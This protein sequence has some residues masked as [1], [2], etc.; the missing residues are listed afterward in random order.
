MSNVHSRKGQRQGGLGGRSHRYQTSA[1]GVAR[2]GKSWKRK[3]KPGTLGTLLRFAWR[4]TM[5]SWEGNARTRTN[6]HL[7]RQPGICGRRFP[8]PMPRCVLMREACDA[9]RLGRASVRLATRT[10]RER[11]SAHPS[12]V[13][14]SAGHASGR[15]SG[16]TQSVLVAKFRVNCPSLIFFPERRS[17]FERVVTCARRSERKPSVRPRNY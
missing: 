9:Y 17:T 2:R 13:R 5:G 12:R 15:V 16:H 3:R 11:S 7:S 6:L 1:R 8:P 10:S 4:K 14:A